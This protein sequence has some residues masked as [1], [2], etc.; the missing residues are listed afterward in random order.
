MDKV[1]AQIKQEDG[2]DCIGCM[3]DCVH[4]DVWS[5]DCPDELDCGE[6]SIFKLELV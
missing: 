3:F 4:G 5:C 2:K 6:N 1:V